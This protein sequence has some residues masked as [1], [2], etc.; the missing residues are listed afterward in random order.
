MTRTNRSHRRRRD[1]FEG[2]LKDAATP[3][4]RLLVVCEWLVAEAWANE[5]VG[6]AEELVLVAVRELRGEEVQT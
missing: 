1:W 6:R 5:Q 3:K 4:G 2:R